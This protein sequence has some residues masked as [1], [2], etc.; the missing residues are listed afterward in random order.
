MVNWAKLPVGG[1]FAEHYHEEME[2][3]FIVLNGT[4]EMRV[5]EET[6]TLEKGDAV[7]VPIGKR[8]TMRNPGKVDIEF[9]VFG[10][11]TGKEGETIIL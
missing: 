2:E 7:I 6:E 10:V 5:G 11:S 9:I 1:E 4:A 3:V 8:H